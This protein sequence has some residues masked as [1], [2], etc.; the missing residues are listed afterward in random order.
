MPT[1]VRYSPASPQRA[2]LKGKRRIAVAVVLIAFAVAHL[3]GALLLQRSSP[4]NPD[5]SFR[6]A[7]YED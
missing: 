7:E 6:T 4:A 5:G 1:D 3:I 2:Q